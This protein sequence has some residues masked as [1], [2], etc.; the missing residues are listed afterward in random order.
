VANVPDAVYI[1]IE[2]I[3][4]GVFLHKLTVALVCPAGTVERVKTV[5][6]VVALE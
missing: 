6:K 4:S 2:L 5:L 3:D 1:K